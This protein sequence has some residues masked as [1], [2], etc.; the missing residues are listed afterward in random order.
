[1]NRINLGYY[2]PHTYWKISF[3]YIFDVPFVAT[4]FYLFCSSPVR[5]SSVIYSPFAV[6][7]HVFFRMS[8]IC[9]KICGY[10]VFLLFILYNL[11]KYLEYI[12]LPKY[13]VKMHFLTS[14]T[15]T[16]Q[17]FILINHYVA[18]P[19]YQKLFLQSYKYIVWIYFIR[20]AVKPPKSTITALR[21]WL[22]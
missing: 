3:E 5:I 15:I 10:N 13:V 17:I 11:Q 14:R 8:I 18:I 22:H 9:F 6:I 1:M 12:R 16:C 21:I 4:S 20:K 19:F 7:Y 2:D